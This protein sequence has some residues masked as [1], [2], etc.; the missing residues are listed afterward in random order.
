MTE[1]TQK[2]YEERIAACPIHALVNIDLFLAA[3]EV[4]EYL[5]RAFHEI[6]V[7]R[8]DI[9]FRPT[10]RKFINFRVEMEHIVNS[11]E[12]SVDEVEYLFTAFTYISEYWIAL[13]V[14]RN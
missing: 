6:I 7:A 14:S 5:H 3:A 1:K 12:L 2:T 10:A 4:P 9:G 8:G 13:V 11:Y